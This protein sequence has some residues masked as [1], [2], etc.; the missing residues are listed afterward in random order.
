MLETANK[1]IE[2][3]GKLKQLY[4]AAM[5]ENSGYLDEKAL[6]AIS[7]CNNVIEASNQLLLEDTKLLLNMNEKLDL[8]LTNTRKES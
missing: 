6:T 4:M 5:F 2:E 8:L 7:I 3:I 1:L